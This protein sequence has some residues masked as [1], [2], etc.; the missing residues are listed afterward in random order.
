MSQPKALDFTKHTR[1]GN[2]EAEAARSRQ[3]QVAAASR[4]GDECFA[5]YALHCASPCKLNLERAAKKNG[6]RGGRVEEEERKKGVGKGGRRRTSGGRRKEEGRWRG[7]KESKR[8]EGKREQGGRK[9]FEG[10]PH[11][12][13]MGFLL[14]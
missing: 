11:S 9:L 13:R 5:L 12:K 10:T 4:A 1:K 2:T 14:R 8:R 7:R 6:R 3:Q